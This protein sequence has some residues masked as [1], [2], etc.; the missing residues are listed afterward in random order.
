MLH[1]VSCEEMR[2]MDAHTIKNLKVPSAVLMERAAL[3]IAEEV[4][5]ALKTHPG[6]ILIVCGTGNNGG[7]GAALA[8]ILF[9]KGIKADLLIAG[10]EERFS[11]DMKAQMESCR[12]LGVREVQ[13][14]DMRVYSIIVDAIFGTGLTREVTGSAR[15]LI[16]KMGDAGAFVIAADIPS[17][18]SGDTGAVCGCAVKADVTVTMECAKTGQLLYPGALYTGRLIIA[19][20]GIFDDEKLRGTLPFTAFSLEDHDIGKLLPARD[21]AGNKGTFGK[22][23]VIAGLKGMCGAALLAGEA[24]LRSGAGM[25]KIMT[26]EANRTI[27]QTAFPEALL[28]V[29]RKKEE[30]P[31]LIRENLAWADAVAV[32][33]GL[34]NSKKTRLIVETLLNEC[35]KPLVID[36]DGLNVIGGDTDLLSRH[37]GP[38]YITPHMGEMARLSGKTI[39]DLK[40]DPVGSALE[41]AG[42]SGA[43]V[44]LKD[45]RTVIADKNGT[46]FINTSGNAGMATAGSGDVLSG[47]LA[48]FLAQGAD[49]AYAGALAA[50]VH[51]KA[52]D[53]AR[54][55]NGERGMTAS[56][57]IRALSKI[58]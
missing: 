41:Y 43:Q 7:D 54:E 23:L 15:V 57:I 11:A 50:F 20:I 2:A 28:S 33:P 51:G 22:V 56:D 19:E 53:R 37:E 3:S 17:G 5:A 55:I 12:A 4:T 34:G 47:I 39:V 40:A 44:L 8:R 31:E 24:A 49:P 25:V 29:Y 1:V 16:E 9:I 32:G 30:I 52:G 6:R 36:A 14:P 48:G 42:A 27:V 21:P 13:D 35:G 10:N 18:I 46:V 26:N 38:L 58:I 45:A